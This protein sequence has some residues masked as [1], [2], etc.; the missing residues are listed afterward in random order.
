MKGLIPPRRRDDTELPARSFGRRRGRCQPRQVNHA[1]AGGPR[2]RWPRRTRQPTTHTSFRL[3]RDATR[4]HDGKA[5]QDADGLRVTVEATAALTTTKAPTAAPSTTKA[6]R[7]PSLAPTTGAP[8]TPAS[9]RRR[10]PRPRQRRR[11]PTTAAPTT[12]APPCRRRKTFAEIE[13]AVAVSLQ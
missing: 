9:G 4:A 11:L 7:A 5:D 8:T 2:R 12:A 13:A 3:C 10:P 6:R 1:T